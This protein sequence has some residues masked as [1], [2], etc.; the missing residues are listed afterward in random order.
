[1]LSKIRSTDKRILYYYD[2]RLSKEARETIRQELGDVYFYETR[3]G[4]EDWTTPVTVEKSVTVNFCNT[5]ITTAPLLI[6]DYAEIEWD[7]DSVVPFIY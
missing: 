1:M 6:E 5:L 4:D 7:E 3:H 2:G